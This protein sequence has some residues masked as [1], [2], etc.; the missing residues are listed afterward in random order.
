MVGAERD[1]KGHVFVAMVGDFEE[2][3]VALRE[4]PVHRNRP[5][6]VQRPHLDVAEV[7]RQHNPS[8]V[9]VTSS[10]YRSDVIIISE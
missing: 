9:C 1:L 2:D 8:Y 5:L 3:F 6:L 4:Q 7:G 10:S